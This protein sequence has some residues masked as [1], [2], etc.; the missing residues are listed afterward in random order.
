M[1]T[2]LTAVVVAVVGVAGTLSSPVL[3][4]RLNMRSKQQELDSERQQR[5]DEREADRRQSNLRE[6]REAYI[7]MNAAARAFRQALKNAVFDS[8]SDSIAELERA[9]VAFAGRYAEGQLIAPDPVLEVAGSVSAE[10][11][12]VYGKVKRLSGLGSGIVDPDIERQAI[13]ADLDGAVR[14][15]IQRLRHVMRVDLGV[16]TPGEG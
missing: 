12:S 2:D 3:A 6:R 9:R 15:V 14:G 1:S 4:Q 16:A 7:G 8:S 10:L 11:A 5:L 13:L